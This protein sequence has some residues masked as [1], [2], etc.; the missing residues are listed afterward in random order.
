MSRETTYLESQIQ[1][2]N[3]REHIRKRPGMYIGI[4]NIKGF[5]EM[6]QGL[7]SNTFL[8]ANPNYFQ[9]EFQERYSGKI[10]FKNIKG[11][12][13]D[14]WATEHILLT[15]PFWMEA[16]VLNNLSSDFNIK[17]FGKNGEKIAEQKFKKGELKKGKVE[18]KKL[19]CHSV[20]VDFKLDKE[21]WKDNFEWNTNYIIHQIKDFAYL[22]KNV[23][24]EIKYKLDKEPCRIIYHFKNGL[25]DRIDIERLNG[26]CQSYFMTYLEE[27]FNGFSLELAFA[28][29]ENSVD[30]GFLKSY[31]NDHHTHQGGTHHQGLVTGLSIALRKY[32]Q[33][34]H[35]DKKYSFPKN[36]I[37]SH[38]IAALN[39]KMDDPVFEGSTKN[40]LGNPEI[41][42]PIS[43][44]IS[45]I[46]FEQLITNE[47]LAKNLLWNFEI[48]K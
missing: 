12:L 9:F 13:N 24:F 6:I 40:K 32:V 35:L 43:N 17:F 22:Y 45:K 39:L 42:K 25:K 37:T 2:V 18:D 46:L 38:L 3:H 47:D 5:M 31:V 29:R 28:F 15:S 36:K 19:N 44:F 8:N 26:L 10:K 48:R 4:V 34:K 33:E 30:A 21:I 11:G 7:L 20:E 14:S 23:K 27:K 41:V 16:L 1:A